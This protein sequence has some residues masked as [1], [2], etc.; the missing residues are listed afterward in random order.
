MTTVNVNCFRWDCWVMASSSLV[1]TRAGTCLEFY[2]RGCPFL[3]S[4]AVQSLRCKVL[5]VCP[6]LKKWLLV[7]R[8]LLALHIPLS[9]YPRS[10]SPVRTPWSILSCRPHGEAHRW[11]K[12]SV[13][14]PKTTSLKAGGLLTINYQVGRTVANQALQTRSF[15]TLC[16][17]NLLIPR[18]ERQTQA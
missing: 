18:L 10:T 5:P 1:L 16:Q 9:F 12:S 8:P 11:L 17:Y 7:Q 14:F 2:M 13:C 15:R 4:G 3:Q 6:P